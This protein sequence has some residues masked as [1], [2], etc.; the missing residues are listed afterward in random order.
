MPWRVLALVPRTARGP[1]A[2][3]WS[4]GWSWRDSPP[5]LHSTSAPRSPPSD[6]LH[7][8][9]SPAFGPL[10]ETGPG[11]TAASFT[12]FSLTH[13]SPI[14]DAPPFSFVVVVAEWWRRQG[15]PAKFKEEKKIY[16][17]LLPPTG[18]NE[19]WPNVKGKTSERIEHRAA[20]SPNLLFMGQVR[21]TRVELLD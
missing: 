20:L 9:F 3:G 19:H 6:G 15:A 13:E 10:V 1:C 16:G 17:A 21:G 7:R 14:S 12:L 5:Q 18:Q 4:A 8:S 2:G 11:L